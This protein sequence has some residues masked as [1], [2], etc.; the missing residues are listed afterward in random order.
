MDREFFSRSGVRRMLVGRSLLPVLL[1]GLACGSHTPSS[2]TAPDSGPSSLGSLGSLDGSLCSGNDCDGDGYLVPADCDDFNPQVNPEAYDFIGDGIDNDCDGTVDNPVVTC[3]TVPSTP[4]GTPED[5]ARAGDLCAQRS[6]TN[7]GTI[8]DPLVRAAWGQVSGSGGQQVWTSTTKPQQV[9]IVSAFGQNSPRE[10]K[11]M[12]GLANGPWG[13]ADP[14]NAPALDPA[15]F[16]LD[17]AC[18]DIPLT[19][20]DCD[21]LTDNSP[22]GAVSVQDWAELTL[23]VKVPRNAGSMHFDFL[24]FSSEFNQWWNSSANDAFFALVSSKTLSGTNV[25]RDAHGLAIT[26]NSDFFQLCPAPPGPSGLAAAKA[27]ALQQCVGIS[28]DS[29]QGILG[30][31][32][33][34]GYDGAATGPNDTALAVDGSE[35]IYGG[36]SGWLTTSF[37]VTPGEE[38]QLRIVI[39]DTFDGLKDSVVLIDQLGWDPGPPTGVSR[40]PR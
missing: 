6:K 32:L 16:H 12:A 30:T 38:L 39:M 7:A 31:L 5:F 28:G 10:G 14:R 36:G 1:S 25:A 37:G 27:Q 11:T 15:G 2:F 18:S 13:G 35:Y 24:F 33:G 20:L 22:V 40:P 19:G 34:T 21:A 29:S 26:V 9:N 23:W 3:E 4:P 17:D 8:F